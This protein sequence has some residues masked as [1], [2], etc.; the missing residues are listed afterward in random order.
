MCDLRAD[1]ARPRCRSEDGSAGDE[2]LR[3]EDP[4]EGLIDV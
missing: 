2:R 3:E 1:A 4:R